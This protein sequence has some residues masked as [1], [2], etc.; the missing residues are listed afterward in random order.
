VAGDAAEQQAEPDARL[1]AAALL[2]HLDGGEADIVGILEGGDGTAAV[3]GD[4]EL[5]GQAVKRAGVEDV[6][7]PGAGEGP[8]VEQFLRVDARGRRAGDVAD[9]VGARTAGDEAE[10]LDRLEQ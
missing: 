8:R 10:V 9:T 4:I 2:D 6:E 5:A 3:E 7:M 1:D